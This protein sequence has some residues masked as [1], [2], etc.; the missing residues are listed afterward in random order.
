MQKM[1]D[2]VQGHTAPQGQSQKSAF[3]APDPVCFALLDTM[4]INCRLLDQKCIPVPKAQEAVENALFLKICQFS[5]SFLSTQSPARTDSHPLSSGFSWLSGR[6]C[7]SGSPSTKGTKEG[8]LESD[9]LKLKIL[10]PNPS[11]AEIN[12]IIIMEDL[13]H[14]CAPSHYSAPRVTIRKTA[15]SPFPNMTMLLTIS[16]CDFFTG[17]T[18]TLKYFSFILRKAASMACRW[19]KEKHVCLVMGLVMCL[20]VHKPHSAVIGTSGTA[21]PHKVSLSK[22]FLSLRF[23]P[24]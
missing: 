11:S 6:L 4:V 12:D 18:E 3:L 5:S 8:K 21:R 1:E 9:V 13:T 24:S 14:L 20:E 10:P 16:Q 2:L 23:V 15:H 19:Q 22:T 7:L 17:Q